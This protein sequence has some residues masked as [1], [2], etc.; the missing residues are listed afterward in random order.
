MKDDR[1]IGDYV[2]FEVT[3]KVW[4]TWDNIK[5]LVNNGYYQNPEVIINSLNQWITEVKATS[6]YR[7]THNITGSIYKTVDEA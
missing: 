4:V 3:K 7:T 6:E 5:D 2:S 1:F